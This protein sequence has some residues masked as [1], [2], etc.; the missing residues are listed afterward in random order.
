MKHG[1]N[2][3][4]G[5]VWVQHGIYY[6]DFCPNEARRTSRQDLHSF[7]QQVRQGLE[8]QRDDS[9]ELQLLFPMDGEATED[10]D[11]SA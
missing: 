9:F 3:E 1:M 2:V 5:N 10:E 7:L 11:D 4:M 6:P 8:R